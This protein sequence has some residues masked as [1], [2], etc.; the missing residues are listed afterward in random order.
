MKKIIF[1]SFATC[2]L[3]IL[4]TTTLIMLAVATVF[5][6]TTSATLDNTL[7]AKLQQ[8]LDSQAESQNLVG[9]SAAVLFPDNEIWLGASGMSN[10]VNGDSMRTDLLFRSGS[11]A[12]NYTATVILQLVEEGKLGLEDSLHQW[13][14]GFDNI[15]STITIRQLLNHTSGIY[16]FVE[17]P[18]LVPIIF[19]DPEKYWTQEEVIST[20]VK[21]PYFEPGTSL[22]YSSS[23][24]VLLSMIIEEATGDY[25]P[26]VMEN[27]LGH[28][29]PLPNTYF[30][31]SDTISA[32]FAHPWF[33][34][35]NNGNLDDIL[36]KCKTALASLSYGTGGVISTAEDL[37]KW[38][39]YLY[40]GNILAPESMEEM[41]DFQSDWYGMGVMKTVEYDKEFWGHT[42]WTPGVRTI[43]FYSPADS[44]SITVLS[45]D[46]DVDQ[47]TV[48]RALLQDVYALDHP[49]LS[50]DTSLLQLGDI[51]SKF[52]TTF[53]VY[54]T[55]AKT[56][57]IYTS[58]RIPGTI[59]ENAFTL[60]PSAFQLA[61]GDSQALGFSINADLLALKEYT[62]RLTLESKFSPLT[63]KVSR[64]IRFNV[65]SSSLKNV[66][67]NLPQKFELSQNYPNPF[68]PTT[69]IQY[70]LPQD[71][72]VKLSVYNTFGQHIQTLFDES[73]NAGRYSHVWNAADETG[74][75]VSFG[76]YLYRIKF[77]D[78]LG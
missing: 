55:G 51:S 36:Y 17:Y 53:Y 4:F 24:Y 14:P 25:F 54:N 73:K 46:N 61:A 71:G 50:F 9:L 77:P 2:H 74:N 1:N 20:F 62:I 65:L 43:V 15:D 39:K 52:D 76:I 75:K 7:A 42:G 57:S 23:N 27:R 66:Q 48:F 67:T 29:P 37:A 31:W 12:K 40:E 13:L 22:H 6:K 38:F 58:L 11:V 70:A 33:D 68:N 16:H 41:V 47:W 59:D 10:P 21:K 28:L 5:S 64:A 49:R 72:H 45:N 26:V 69:T 3:P 34:L 78:Q 44:L 56:D 8:T 18:D 19:S 60:A 32:D 35:D 30:T 63:P